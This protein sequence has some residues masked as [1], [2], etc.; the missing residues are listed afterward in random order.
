MS[1]E[2]RSVLFLDVAFYDAS[3]NTFATGTSV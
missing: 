3:E 1:L 2:N